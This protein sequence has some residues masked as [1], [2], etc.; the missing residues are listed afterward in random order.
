MNNITDQNIYI[1]IYIYIYSTTMNCK[2]K[3]MKYMKKY[4]KIK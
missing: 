4:L 3:M 1:Y 2:N